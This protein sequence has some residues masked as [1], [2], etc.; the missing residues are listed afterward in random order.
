MSLLMVND[1]LTLGDKFK[2]TVRYIGRIKSKDGKWI[3]LELDE[4]VGA[5]NGSVNGVRYFHCR[6]KHGIF[7]RYEKIREGLVCEPRE[8]GDGS[9]ASQQA[10]LYEMKIKKLEE[11][12]EALRSAEKGE[13]VE[14]RRENEEIK[15]IVLLLQEK[16]N[17]KRADR[18][19]KAYSELKELAEGSRRHISDIIGLVSEMSEALSRRGLARKKAIQECERHRVMFLVNR[20]I[21]G[22]LDDDAEAVERFK[23]EFESI[24]KKHGINVE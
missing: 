23:G 12:I 19:G 18:D 21:D 22:V 8:M 11:T 2:G 1:R 17:S 5:N 10:H 14:L 13:I 16:I 9:K 24:M 7:I 15:R 6:D 20:I 3:G 4:P